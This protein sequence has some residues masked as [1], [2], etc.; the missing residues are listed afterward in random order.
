MVPIGNT[1][2]F[3]STQIFILLP[4]PAWRMEKLL[5]PCQQ[6]FGSSRN[7]YWSSR[8]LWKKRLETVKNDVWGRRLWSPSKP[9]RQ[10]CNDP[11]IQKT[12]REVLEAIQTTIKDDEHLWHYRDE[13]SDVHHIT[14][15]WI[16]LHYIAHKLQILK[17][18]WQGKMLSY[19]A[20]TCHQV[21]WHLW[22]NLSAGWSQSHPQQPPCPLQDP[23]TSTSSSIH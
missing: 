10:R 2:L 5:H 16:Q 19:F 4:W 20:V 12:T 6:L 13:I 22:L 17:Q 7:P 11:E 3:G 21:T 15:E 23:R 14:D 9:Y 1:P 18:S 8:W